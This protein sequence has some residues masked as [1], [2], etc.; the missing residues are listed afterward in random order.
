MS[1][2]ICNGTGSRPNGNR[3]SMCYGTGIDHDPPLVVHAPGS[4]EYELPGD[5][6]TLTREDCHQIVSSGGFNS[7]PR[8]IRGRIAEFL[9]WEK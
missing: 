8:E 5:G 3:C 9:G 1:C 6:L 2:S 7:L 4:D